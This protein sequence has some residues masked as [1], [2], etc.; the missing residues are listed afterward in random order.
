M[1][2][3]QIIY[4]KKRLVELCLF[5]GRG[6]LPLFLLNY[7]STGISISKMSV[8]QNYN[9]KSANRFVSRNGDRA[10]AQFQIVPP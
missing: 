4:E 5:Y 10:G 6:A 8:S 3:N 1:C 9:K 7:I 2:R